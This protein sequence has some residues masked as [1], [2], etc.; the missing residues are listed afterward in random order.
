MPEEYFNITEL[1][2]D[3]D[4]YIRTL[5]YAFNEDTNLMS[6]DVLKKKHYITNKQIASK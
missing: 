4:Q 2:Q 1:P 5:K 6:E 3:E